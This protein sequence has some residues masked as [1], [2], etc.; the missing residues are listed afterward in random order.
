MAVLAPIVITLS[1]PAIF[2]A[3]GIGLAL[4]GPVWRS[5]SWS[6]R[7]ALALFGLLSLAAFW[8]NYNGVTLA[9][10]ESS[11][12][13]AYT[14]DFWTGAFPP[15]GDPVGLA[16]WLLLAHSGRMFGYPIGFDA[17]GGAVTFILFAIGSVVFFKQRRRTPLALLLFPFG[18]ALIAASLQKY[19]YGLSGRISQWAVPAI[20]ILAAAGF[21]WVLGLLSRVKARRLVM[22]GML[23][24]LAF[25][26]VAQGVADIVHPYKAQRDREARDFARWFWVEKSRDAELLCAWN[27]LQLPFARPQGSHVLGNGQYWSN[28][29][30]YSPRLRRGEAADLSRVTDDHPIRVVFLESMIDQPGNGFSGWLDETRAEYQQVGLERHRPAHYTDSPD[31]EQEEVV[32]FEFKP[33]TSPDAKRFER[34]QRRS[35]KSQPTDDAG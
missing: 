29:K 15:L 25:F 34:K 3:A 22:N 32:V 33:R 6:N 18:L 14:T 2:V 12:E 23:G 24:F 1:N 27:D 16:K 4:L 19:P 17:G 26:G 5:A 13:L 35:K 9:Q 11:V 30:I 31:F 20:C 21:A 7:L 8:F 28:Q 10:Y